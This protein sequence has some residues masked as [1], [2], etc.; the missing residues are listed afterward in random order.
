MAI[1]I[2]ILGNI[3]AGKSLIASMLKERLS[4][5][6]LLQMDDY[7]RK[8]NQYTTIQ[9]ENTAFDVFLKDT[10]ALEYSIIETS[11]VSKN[12]DAVVRA[13]E[14]KGG[15][16]LKIYLHGPKKV[17]LD[18]VKNREAAGYKRPPFPYNMTIEKS[19][20]YI[21]KAWATI[22]ADIS[23]DTS[24]LPPLAIVN[25]ILSQKIMQQAIMS[26]SKAQD[27]NTWFYESSS[28]VKNKRY[29]PTG[30]ILIEDAIQ[31]LRNGHEPVQMLMCK[32]DGSLRKMTNVIKSSQQMHYDVDTYEH[33]GHDKYS[34][35]NAG[36]KR[37]DWRDLF[38]YSLDEK[39]NIRLVTS[40]LMR[41]NG[42]KVWH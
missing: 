27:A 7:R 34:N 36:I 8:Y 17:L 12:F 39:K 40:R 24:K 22:P 26:N 13:V 11:G 42:Q 37:Y 25:Y 38:L 4:G 14:R 5:F 3:G 31:L 30:T 33:K 1:T 16:F 41:L 21:A 28:P 2:G 15:A 35:E 6:A 29:H 18:R 9:G 20:D 32:K 10:I 23:I 19:M